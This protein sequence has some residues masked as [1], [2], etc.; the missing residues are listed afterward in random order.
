MTPASTIH[1]TMRPG[2]KGAEFRCNDPFED[3]EWGRVAIASDDDV[4]RRCAL[5][6][7]RI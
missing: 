2:T 7:A 4:E 6:A 3:R 1:G 5:S